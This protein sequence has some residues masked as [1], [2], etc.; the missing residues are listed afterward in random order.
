LDRDQPLELIERVRPAR[1]SFDVARAEPPPSA[2]ADFIARILPDGCY[3]GPEKR[4]CER[5]PI[6]AP[7]AVM[8]LGNGLEPAGAPFMALTR[9]ISRSGIGLVSTRAACTEFIAV[10]WPCVSGQGMQLVV[11]VL[12]CRPL[13]S[14]YDIGGKFLTRM[15]RSDDGSQSSVTGPCEDFRGLVT[16]H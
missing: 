13:R 16:S 3:A 1:I 7:V 11:Q 4:D 12:R 14:F 8:P 9:N 6:V 5:F 15:D 10:E 2:I